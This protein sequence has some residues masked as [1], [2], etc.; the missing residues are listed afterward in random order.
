MSWQDEIDIVLQ[1]WIAALGGE[2]GRQPWRRV[3]RAQ[4]IGDAG[5]YVVDIRSSD[6]TADQADNLRL[7]GPD[8]R[9]VRDGFPVMEATI[10]GELMRLR[11]AEF[12]APAE[13]YLW[14]LRQ[15]PTFLVTALREGLSSLADAGL[16]SLL[17]RGEV[18]GV[19]GAVTPPPGL[20]P[21]QEDAYR[22]CLGRGL[23]LVWGPP[24]T[25]K[26]R[27]LRSAVGDLMAAGKRILLVS[28]TNIAVD[29]ALLGVVRER[30][31]QPGD[32]VRVGPPQLHEIA[33]DP[34]VC[35]PLM[36]RARL[37]E[38]EEQRR[39]VAVDLLEMNHRR[40]RL[41]DLQARLAGFEPAAYDA[42][43]NLLAE[44]GR[45]T[46]ETG[47]ALTQCELQ[48]ENGLQEI[49]DARGEFEAATGATA[50]ADP[51][52]SLWAEIGT[53]E[54]ELAKVEKTAR[55]SEARALVAKGTCDTAESEI[56]ALRQPN[57]KVRWRDRGR[58]KE[59]QSRLD[60]SRPEYEQLHAAAVEA[61]QIASAF[62]Q[63]TEAAI[64]DLSA[65][66]PLS[67][68]EI[69]RR[70][71]AA[72]Q[73]EI[74]VRELE[75]AQFVAL[76]R[77]T[78]LRATRAAA[79]AAEALITAC[80]Q[81][82]WPDMHAQATALRVEIARDN[83][84]RRTVEERHTELQE[85][86]E[87]L[88]R[89]AQGEIIR[90]ARLVAT[91]LARFRTVKA[92]LDGPYDVVLIDEVGASTLP[93]VLLAVAKAA[94]CAVLLGDF[95]QLGPILPR[96]LQDSDRADI[97][98]WLV[99]DPFRH[100]GITTLAEAMSHPACLVLDTQHRFGPQVMRLANLVAYDGLLKAGRAVRRHGDDDDP[101]I[102]LVDTDGL[103]ELAEVRRVSRNA[104]WWAAGL[105][106]A[107]ALVELHHEYGEATGVVTPYTVQAD[108][109]L[110]ALRDVEPG[111]RPLAEV[112]TAHRFQGREFP[113]VVFDTVEPWHDGG[114][115]MG[116]ASARPGSTAWQQTG[117]R[118][119]N[120]ATT[121]VQHRLYVIVSRERVWTAKPGTALGHLGTLLRDR[122]VRSVPA[123][124]LITPPEWEPQNLGP[125][126][127]RLAEVLARHVTITDIHDE[128]SFYEQFA[129][130]VSQAQSSIWL[131]SAWVASRVRSLLPL[132]QAA[133]GRGVRVTIFVR[134]PSDTLQQKK[135][136]AEALAALRAVV[137]D[138]I[139]VNVT[140]EKVVIIDDH[141]VMMGSLNALSQ[142]RSREVMVTMR[143]H[144][145]A[146]K[147]L[148]HL[149]AE[150]FSK[151]PRCGACNEQQVDLRR[152]GSSGNWYW[153]CYNKA[154]PERGKGKYKAW[155]REVT[156]R[157][158]RR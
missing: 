35:L 34:Q 115:W 76:N 116:Q 122:Q 51:V 144:H 49:E 95:M 157:Q 24:G 65:S 151:P 119:F 20:L 101:E 80:T 71:S 6:L 117:V 89:D 44:P 28:G 133:V 40:E 88:A 113:I 37:A 145:W 103:H 136:F 107:R 99:T 123:T 138:V 62:R 41:Q 149:H 112:G 72:A 8:E 69:K 90:A 22:A 128:R 19:P 143:G 46:A 146:R 153:H 152:A 102:V 126:G 78:E 110:E 105:L 84:Q 13:P 42:A 7:A 12:A 155:T 3:G 45:S 86:Y 47:S 82:G 100:C 142:H 2:Q 156:L 64:A 27:V 11:V 154:C 14:R 75:Q 109:T 15:E 36:V 33:D 91:T 56:A 70:D 140:H 57:G 93:E 52:R 16:A 9:G 43:V 118:L 29:N 96:T 48:A 77:L 55:Q 58:L 92:V 10:D 124:S 121:R 81:R 60:T 17:A 32:V 94:Q 26:T 83:A 23:W 132:L 68:D 31:H 50:E 114:L 30:R 125:E 63:D 25:G 111:G 66:A 21:A 108:A 54:A 150:E 137:P 147:L 4:P 148:S 18:R 85:Q 1:E 87:K 135:Q 129:D 139:E 67:R 38:V 53:I 141:T 5:V 79:L 98:R 158:P 74:R 97:R 73:A 59:A 120:V 134:D 104:G 61:R 131:W 106:L 39:A 127:T 130:L